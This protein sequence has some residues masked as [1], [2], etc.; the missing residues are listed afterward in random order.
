MEKAHRYE[1]RLDW[2]GAR[3]GPT[4]NYETYSREFC[5]EISGK[6]ALIGSADPAFG[7][8]AC[9][10][11][12]E[13]MLLAPLSPCQMLSYLCLCV[14]YGLAG[15]AYTGIARGTSSRQTPQR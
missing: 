14:R 1:L 7:G 3:Q 5:V 8:D 11:N 15:Q 6:P 4:Q 2:I 9:L 13:E 10:Y 12:P